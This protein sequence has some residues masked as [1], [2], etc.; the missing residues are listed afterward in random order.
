[1]QLIQVL[2]KIGLIVSYLLMKNM[3]IQVTSGAMVTEFNINLRAYGI[4]S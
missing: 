2:F 3:V 1:M 4:G